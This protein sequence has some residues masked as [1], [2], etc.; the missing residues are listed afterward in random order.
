M[1]NILV[2][3]NYNGWKIYK[4]VVSSDETVF[5]AYNLKT[6]ETV[7]DESLDAIKIKINFIQDEFA[8]NWF[9]KIKDSLRN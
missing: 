1:F 8:K 7:Q 5:Y 2:D 9:K 6:K 3:K 4:E